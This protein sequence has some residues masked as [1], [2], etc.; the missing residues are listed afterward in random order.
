MACKCC[1]LSGHGEIKCTSSCTF[2]CIF[3]STAHMAKFV[4]VDIKAACFVVTVVQTYIYVI[5]NRTVWRARNLIIPFSQGSIAIHHLP[6]AYSYR[7]HCWKTSDG[8]VTIVSLM[9]CTHRI[10]FTVSSMTLGSVGFKRLLASLSIF[11]SKTSRPNFQVSGPMWVVNDRLR[12]F[13]RYFTPATF[14]SYI[15]LYQ[16][17]NQHCFF[18]K[19]FRYPNVRSVWQFA[20]ANY[21][22]LSEI[23]HLGFP[24]FKENVAFRG[25]EIGWSMMGCYWLDELW[26]YVVNAEYRAIDLICQR[27]SPLAIT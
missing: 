4:G 15:L 14:S 16:P 24:M 23:W 5:Y 3:F 18:E 7:V 22:K 11:G 9:P 20:E 8:L 21:C 27:W 19:S 12:T 25:Y 26:Y 1:Q 13:A 2:S 17:V 6:T 10:T